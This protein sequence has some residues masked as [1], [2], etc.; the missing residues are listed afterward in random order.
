MINAVQGIDAEARRVA[1]DPWSADWKL[2]RGRA[3]E[4]L[5]QCHRYRLEIDST[6]GSDSPGRD[7]WQ[8]SERMEGFVELRLSGPVLE[9]SEPIGVKTF[10][11]VGAGEIPSRSYSM[12]YP[13][14]CSVAADVVQAPSLFNVTRL[15]FARDGDGGLGD[16]RL[17]YFPG[18]NTSS[19]LFIDRCGDPPTQTRLTLFAWSNTFLVSVGLD[20]RYFDESAGFFVKDW[21]LDDWPVQG[22]EKV[23]ANNTID[24]FQAEGTISYR[25]E[26]RLRLVHTPSGP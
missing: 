17:E 11:I 14:T 10:E 5:A 24:A 22:G 4:R 19:H 8:F 1:A 26:M 7:G 16:I 9:F 21:I 23:I 13:D 18:L 6:S 25:T 3:E 12:S 15:A 2:W 20:G